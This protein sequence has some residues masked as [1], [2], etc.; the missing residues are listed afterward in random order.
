MTT[1]PSSQSSDH[2]LRLFDAADFLESDS[3]GEFLFRH[4]YRLVDR[5]RV[6]QTLS[7]ADGA[8]AV[9]PAIYRCLPG[10]GLE[11]RIDARA[12]D[13]LLECD[14]ER[15]LDDL[16]KEAAHRRGESVDDVKKL[17]EDAVRQLVERGF[18]IPVVDDDTQ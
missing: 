5:H 10:M 16:V 6:D 12:L 2:I 3:G 8:Y 17:V 4:A 1:A 15:Q 13:V 9:R 14:G 7:F 18:M 11:A